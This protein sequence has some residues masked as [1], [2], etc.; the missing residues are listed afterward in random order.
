MAFFPPV[1]SFSLLGTNWRNL[2]L[3]FVSGFDCCWPKN[4]KSSGHVNEV[5]YTQS[6]KVVT[7]LTFWPGIDL[8]Y[9]LIDIG[10]LASSCPRL[11]FPILM[12]QIGLFQ[13]ISID[14]SIR[15][16]SDL[17]PYPRFPKVSTICVSLKVTLG[18]RIPGTHDV[19]RKQQKRQRHHTC[20]LQF[21]CDHGESSEDTVCGTSDGD[22]PLWAGALGD[23]DASAAL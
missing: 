13:S 1:Y 7:L 19:K 15:L 14:L 12:M 5:T 11:L 6:G 16:S 23:V 20:L 18:F 9:L 17:S 3:C 4:V 22:D 10:S 2:P 8:R 21:V